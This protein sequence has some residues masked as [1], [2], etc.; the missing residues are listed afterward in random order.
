VDK[1]A[2]RC[3]AYLTRVEEEVLA[4]MLQCVLDVGICEDETWRFAS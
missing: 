4:V 3:N 1:S 2:R